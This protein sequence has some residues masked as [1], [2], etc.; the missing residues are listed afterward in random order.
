MDPVTTISAAVIGTEFLKEG[1]KFLWNQADQIIKRHIA[2]KDERKKAADAAKKTIEVPAFLE[3]PPALTVDDA[4]AEKRLADL[5]VMKNSIEPYL[6]KDLSPAEA[7]TVKK[8]LDTLQSLVEAIYHYKFRVNPE[9]L[10]NIIHAGNGSHIE[11][12]EV[13][14]DIGNVGTAQ[15]KVDAQD[16]SSI[17]I[18]K[19]SQEIK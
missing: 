5:T 11:A 10:Q 8:Y 16:H 15:N 4:E 2:R 9:V 7:E 14:Q 6:D 18:K 12:D 13:K 19:I 17:K 1:I 3:T